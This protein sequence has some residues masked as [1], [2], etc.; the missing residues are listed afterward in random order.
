MAPLCAL[1]AVAACVSPTPPALPLPEAAPRALDQALEAVSP[2]DS[3][4]VILRI[5]DG[6]VLASTHGAAA[7]TISEPP[8]SLLK[9][10][11]AIA[12]LRAGAHPDREWTCTGRQAPREKLRC[13]HPRG[14]GKLDLLGALERSC[15]HYFYRMLETLPPDA[16][17]RVLREAGLGAPTGIDAAAES[18]GV[19]HVDSRPV[20]G[21]ASALGRTGEIRVTPL[22]AAVMA[23]WLATGGA[24]V[25]PRFH[26]AGTEKR[27]AAQPGPL[28]SLVREGLRRA[29]G[30]K[31]TAAA[32]GEAGFDA[33]GKTG[34]AGWVNGWK[35]H[36]WFAGY[37]P[38]GRPEIAISVFVRD[39]TGRRDAVPLAVRALEEYRRRRDSL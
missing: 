17:A 23:A 15:N 29:A 35:T 12:A 34:T 27:I 11:I 4:V 21:L 25:T 9:P 39:G 19:L 13:W 30:P 16:L 14:H 26:A 33:A 38:A 36:G 10:L 2:V 37:W 24:R 18:P 20:E 32:L 3:V 31:G 28:F 7:W 22:Q 6:K 1:W 5:G 8:G